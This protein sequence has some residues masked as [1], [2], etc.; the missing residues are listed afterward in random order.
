MNEK[1]VRVV[2]KKGKAV[3]IKNKSII[4]ESYQGDIIG[5]IVLSKGE[6]TFD[7]D[8]IDNLKNYVDRVNGE[9]YLIENFEG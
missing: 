1:S 4:D 6:I 5:F 8:S 7:Y 9:L 3:K 2:L